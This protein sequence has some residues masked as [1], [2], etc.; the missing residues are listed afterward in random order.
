ML[1]CGWA[2]PADENG[3]LADDTHFGW[4]GD[5]G[6]DEE[7]LLAARHRVRL[8]NR[9][10]GAGGFVASGRQMAR[11]AG[12][13]QGGKK[14]PAAAAGGAGRAGC[15]S[16]SPPTP[17]PR[18]GSPLQPGGGDGGTPP[19]APASRSK[20]KAQR[21]EKEKLKEAKEAEK[22]AKRRE[23]RGGGNAAPSL[24]SVSDGGDAPPAC[25]A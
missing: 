23:R 1:R 22:R 21:E 17:K 7:D 11:P 19:E 25:D 2:T 4:E 6:D 5:D 13:P 20:L 24:G 10:F 14:S 15:A 18:R 9:R 3:D 8:G 16:A 12:P